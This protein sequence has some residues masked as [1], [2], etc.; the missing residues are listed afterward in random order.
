M[1]ALNSKPQDISSLL[2][3][4]RPTLVRTR[5]QALVQGS[6][7]GRDRQG[8]L[9]GI[10]MTTV[11]VYICTY[12]FHVGIRYYTWY[13]MYDI[14]CLRMCV[15]VCMDVCI[16]CIHFCIHMFTN[17]EF[18]LRAS[19]LCSHVCACLYVQL[20]FVYVC[21]VTI[22]SIYIHLHYAHTRNKLLLLVCVCLSVFVVRYGYAFVRV[23]ILMC[24]SFCMSYPSFHIC[25]CICMHIP[26]IAVWLFL[27]AFTNM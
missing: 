12:M 27:V 13:S 19:Y 17:V 14:M 10:S 26:R 21:V 8:P 16:R 24:T 7:P 5:C 9:G 15:H 4:S 20:L 23:Y 18:C 1:Y 2:K 25:F 3:A 11:Y 6:A 22:L